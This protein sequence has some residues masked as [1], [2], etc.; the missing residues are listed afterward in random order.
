METTFFCRLSLIFVQLLNS[1]LIISYVQ[2]GEKSL[3][4]CLCLI[5]G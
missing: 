4:T 3:L 1:F 5:H 2:F